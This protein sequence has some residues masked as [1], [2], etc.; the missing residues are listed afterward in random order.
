MSTLGF[1]KRS[2]SQTL[3]Y[4]ATPVADGYGGFT[5]DDPVEIKGRCEYT[6]ELILSGSTGEEVLS[7]ARVYLNQEVYEGEYLYLGELDD[8]DLESAPTPIN[9]SKSMRIISATKLPQLGSSTNFLYKAYLNIG[10]WH[11]K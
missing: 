4:W 7:K 8:D 6:T 3:V 9:T 10:A 5:F 11:G 2:L 1:I